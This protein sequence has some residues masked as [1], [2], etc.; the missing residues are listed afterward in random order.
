MDKMVAQA[1][2]NDRRMRR[3]VLGGFATTM[4]VMFAVGLWGI[5]EW[6]EK[7][8]LRFGI[9]WLLCGGLTIFVM[10]FAIFDA[11]KVIKEERERDE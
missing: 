8:A 10:I 11:L 2:L 9:Y 1:V 7:S 5:D 6:L 4:L 3:K